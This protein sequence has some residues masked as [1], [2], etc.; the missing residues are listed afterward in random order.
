MVYTNAT[1]AMADINIVVLNGASSSGKTTLAR[2]LQL[3]FQEPYLRFGTDTVH[4]MLPSRFAGGKKTQ[5]ENIVRTAILGMNSCAATFADAGN[6][7]IVDTV[8][9]NRESVAECARALVRYRAFFIG[10]FC[11]DGE[12]RRRSSGRGR[13]MVNIAL[14]QA[15]YVHTHSIY[16]LKISTEGKSP[17]VMAEQVRNLVNSRTK[18]EAFKRLNDQYT[19]SS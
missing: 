9:L 18:P 10:L 11:D 16:D 2:E 6:N 5:N 3:T 13:D 17:S 8:M 12:L 15:R 7:V 19:R 4:S 14:Q 1:E